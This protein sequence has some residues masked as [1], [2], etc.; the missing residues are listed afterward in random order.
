MKTKYETYDIEITNQNNDLILTSRN[1]DTLLHSIPL[2]NNVFY[3]NL[4]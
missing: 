3:I 4:E 1:N 2:L